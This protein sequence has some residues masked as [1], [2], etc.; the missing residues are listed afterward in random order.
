MIT[1]I[2]IEN[3]K[4]YRE[5]ELPLSPL[6]LLIG[7]N[8]SGKSNAIEAMRFLALLA[9]GRRLDDLFAAV[10]REDV[11][12][13]GTASDLALDGADSFAIGCSLSDSNAG[14]WNRFRIRILLEDK[15]M[16]VVEERLW[17]PGE[18]VPLYEV[19]E[20]ASPFSHEM[21]VAYNNF[22]R[23]GVKPSIPCSDQQAVFTQLDTPARF[24]TKK[25]QRTIP[26]VVEA[27]RQALRGILFL[28][29]SPRR[30]RGYSFIADYELAGDGNNLSSVLLN[31]EQ[32]GH[33]DDIL[34]FIRDL[35]E[36]DI[37]G[38]QFIKTPR[39][40]V[41]VQLVETFAGRKQL[42]DA[43][44]LSDGTLRVLAVAA[45]LL[46]APEGSLVIIEEIDNGVHPSR[47]A[48]LLANIRRVATERGL[49][50]LLTSHNPALL[51]SLPDEAVPDVVA[52]YRDPEEGDSRLVRIEELSDYPDLVA[53]GPLG[54]LM[55]EGVLERA[56]KRQRSEE[57]RQEER[58]RWLRKFQAE[59]SRA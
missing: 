4:S 5:A 10:Q 50:V 28:D 12:V 59:A 8:A 33:F 51:D 30:M 27:Y 32:M 41:M 13:R 35:P 7:A 2:S 52:C 48:Q 55:T 58:L 46:S 38:M 29:P 22:A 42:R 26:Q 16:R 9:E 37:S 31:L 14:I 24:S 36:Q 47:A 18:V 15:G 56:L 17:N 1:R 49:S 23:G 19:K 53:R 57:E 21:S 20:P 11:A 45:A 54:R 39:S 43:P 44:V 6:T 3:F 34:S 40:E 25:A